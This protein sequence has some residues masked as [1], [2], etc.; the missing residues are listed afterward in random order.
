ML[1]FSLRVYSIRCIINYIFVFTQHSNSVEKWFCNYTDFLT[2]TLTRY[3]PWMKTDISLLISHLLR[4]RFHLAISNTL[5]LCDSG[6]CLEQIVAS[7][8]ISTQTMKARLLPVWPILQCHNLS[9]RSI[10]FFYS[11]G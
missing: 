1:S 2:I 8:R 3:F 11:T 4:S 7:I 10:R 5:F 9:N 6:L